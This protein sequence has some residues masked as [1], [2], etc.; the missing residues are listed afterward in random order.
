T[1]TV[2]IG[3]STDATLA[4]DAFGNVVATTG[5]AADYNH[6][7]T[8]KP[9]DIT[10]LYYYGARFYD[11]TIGRFISLDPAKNGLNWYVYANNNPLK[12]IDPSGMVIRVT[13]R[14][15][16]KDLLLDLKAL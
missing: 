4:Y 9:Q 7:F 2:S 14:D 10:G 15:E 1:R 12:Y 11:P 8:G 13:G 16:D 3:T 6:R 5:D